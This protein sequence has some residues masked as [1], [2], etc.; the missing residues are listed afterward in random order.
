[1]NLNDNPEKLKEEEQRIL[2][3]LID[4][5]DSVII[6]LDAEQHNLIAKKKNMD[7]SLDPDS[8]ASL[9]SAN[10]SLERIASKK[11]DIVKCRSELY[12]TRL[13]LKDSDADDIEEYKVGLH[14]CSYD[15]DIL[16]A[17]WVT[18]LFRHY[19]IDKHASVK[20]VNHTHGRHG[21]DYVT[22]YMLLARNDVT[23][24]KFDKVDKVTNIFPGN[25]DE[26]ILQIMKNSGFFSS[27]FIDDL[28]QSNNSESI[29]QES[30]EKV[31]ADEFLQELVK[32]RSTPEFKNIVFS[33]Q[34]KQGEII[35]APYN[36]NLIIQGCAGS[37]KSMIMLHRLPIMLF[38]EQKVLSR[39]SVYV[40]SPSQ[41]YIQLAK[42]MRDE[43]EISDINMGTIERYYDRFISEH[44]KYETGDVGEINFEYELSPEN[45]E[46]VYSKKC[47]ED[48]DAYYESILNSE[49]SLEK[50]CELFSVD[51]KTRA[52]NTFSD[53]ITGKFLEAQDVLDA[54]KKILTKYFKSM[55][56]SLAAM[57]H[58]GMTLLDRKQ[59]AVSAVDRCINENKKII[60]TAEEEISK[61]D[62]VKNE[63]AIKNRNKI[64]E[65]ADS[66]IQNIL[67]DK[68]TISSDDEYFLSL[69]DISK[70]ILS[71]TSSFSYLKN[72]FSQNSIS[73]IYKAVS[74][75]G[76]LIG[77]F[78][79]LSWEISRIEDKY[80]EYL[81]PLTIDVENLKK[82]VLSLQ[83]LN[84]HFLSLD[85]YKKIKAESDRLDAADKNAVYNAYLHIM[86]NIGVK[87]TEKEDLFALKCSPYIYLQALYRYKGPASSW[88]S[89][90]TIDEAQ[91]VAPE[92]IRLIKNVNQGH[93]ILNIFGDVNQHIENTKG[94][95]SWDEYNDII[96]YNFYEMNENYRNA[97]QITEYCNKSF[98]MHMRAINLPG[99]G[100]HELNSLSEFRTSVISLLTNNNLVMGA[101]LVKNRDESQAFRKAFNSY[102]TKL[103]DMTDEE[104][105]L[106]ERKWNI[107]CIDDA[108]GLEFNTVIVLSGRMSRNEKYIAFTRALDNLYVYNELIDIDSINK[109]VKNSTDVSKS[110]ASKEVSASVDTGK[111]KE[112]S[113]VSKN[114]QASLFKGNDNNYDRT[115]NDDKKHPRSHLNEKEDSGSH[116]SEDRKDYT[117]SQVRDFFESHG[118]EVVD[119]RSKGGKLWVIGE[120]ETIIPVVNEAIGKFKISGKFGMS[121]DINNR[122]GWFTKTDK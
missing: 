29:E 98:D 70:E 59:K 72:V 56:D 37:G 78:Y 40:I 22:P 32:R 62:S 28:L 122:N 75:I 9:T 111:A 73:D 68:E 49:F 6:N 41:M 82:A 101:I 18:P 86:E 112:A 107:I 8:F 52:S 38:D 31:I 106:N 95:D 44:Y 48:I 71:V 42:K 51:N 76:T 2:R 7:V 27:D 35:Q 34:K 11:N 53:K 97:S 1:M 89:L 67:T 80:Q 120:K 43:L 74:K 36:K 79:G 23:I 65:D 105:S 17:S 57:Q 12:Q 69:I 64:I 45:E 117:N 3:D 93:V 24:G 16:I 46:Y 87:K 91:G 109:A 63:I 118:L 47:I 104:S 30:M 94:I 66:R 33:I 96:D 121:K 85:Q 114:D 90:I 100:V 50:E 92:E 5:L 13:L 58:L 25:V 20:Y 61:L 115:Q 26:K 119:N 103:N 54:N 14:E 110:V 21:E 4:K 60:E 108:K 88:D 39:K 99:N 116:L 83:S 81:K 77:E 10:D 102:D 15:G 84:E 55:M 113:V 19:V